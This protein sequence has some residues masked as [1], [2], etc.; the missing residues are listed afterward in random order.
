MKQK[1]CRNCAY[2]NNGNIGKLNVFCGIFEEEQNLDDYCSLFAEI[3]KYCSDCKYSDEYEKYMDSDD[4]DDH[5]CPHSSHVRNPYD[6]PCG[7]FEL[8]EEGK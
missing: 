7:E 5:M 1:T 8:L 6:F 3:C 2:G 4:I